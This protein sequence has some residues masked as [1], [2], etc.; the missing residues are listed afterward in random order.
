M[1]LMCAACRPASA[2][3]E[4]LAECLQTCDSSAQW[5]L[6]DTAGRHGNSYIL[7]NGECP[8]GD[9]RI[10]F[11][12][13][14]LRYNDDFT[15]HGMLDDWHRRVGCYLAG[16]SRLAVGICAWSLPNPSA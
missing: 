13:P 3:Q 2:G 16:N 14:A 15:V 12:Q 1:R 7:P 8:G 11:Q 6:T 5:R 9:A 4:R 10:F